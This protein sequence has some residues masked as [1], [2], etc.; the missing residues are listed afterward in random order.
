MQ[1]RELSI[2][3]MTDFVN[4]LCLDLQIKDVP[5][6]LR[7]KN[8]GTQ[9]ARL[10]MPARVIE[11]RTTNIPDT[12][13][14]LA[15]EMRHLWQIDNNR[16]DVQAYVESGASLDDY[17]KQEVEID[18]NAY[19]VYVVSQILGAVPTFEKYSAEVRNAMRDMMNL[20]LK[21]DR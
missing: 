6:V 8:I 2:A 11:I 13:F 16:F 14:A 19:A 18:A 7:V 10:K 12:L 15:H 1:Y 5:K 9:I 20:R 4:K 21:G 3:R 17:S